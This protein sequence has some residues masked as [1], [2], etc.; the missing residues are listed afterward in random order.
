MR[1]PR[2]RKK[3]LTCFFF[4]ALYFFYRFFTLYRTV[5]NG[6]GILFT[7]TIIKKTDMRVST[8]EKKEKLKRTKN[9]YF[10]SYLA[11]DSLYLM[12]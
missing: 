7:C 1:K 5:G 4:V 2:V 10:T 11:H 8:D 3:I 6:P 12:G 9:N